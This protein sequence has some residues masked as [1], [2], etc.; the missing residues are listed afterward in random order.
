MEQL[1]AAQG[2]KETPFATVRVSLT[3]EEGQTLTNVDAF[4]VTRR[5]MVRGGG[6]VGERLQ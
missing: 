3:T 1:E 4:Q 5:R 2:V 6:V